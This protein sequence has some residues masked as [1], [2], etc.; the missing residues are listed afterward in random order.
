MGEVVAEMAKDI[1]HVF[2]SRDGCHWLASRS[3]GVFRY[4]GKTIT[5]F[6]TKD[7]L[8]GRDVKG[9]QEDMHGNLFFNTDQGIS[10]FDGRSFATLEPIAAGEWK[11]QANDLWFS[12]VQDSGSVFRY[13]GQSLHRLELPRTKAGDQHYVDFP[14]SK[15][16]NAKFSP[17]DV[18]TI[19]KDSKGNLWFGTAV[20]GA[21]RFDGKSFKWIPEEELQNDSFGTRSIIEDEDGR[22]WFTNM[23]HRYAVN[24]GAEVGQDTASLWYQKEKGIGDISGY[25]QV[26][27]EVFISSELGND[28]ALWMANLGGVVWRYDGKSM[29]QYPVNENGERHWIFSIYKDRQGMLWI[30]TQDNGVYRFNG[31]AFEK[32]RP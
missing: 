25:N 11:K 3:E 19:F 14:R 18:Y 6:S 30:G 4:D 17:Y 7:G 22:F 21:C 20:L 16:P 23:R 8:P 12:G 1:F 15:F 31:V 28:G 5:R 13:D 9:I 27:Y 10:K 29:K 26:D 24:D 2:Q 32:F